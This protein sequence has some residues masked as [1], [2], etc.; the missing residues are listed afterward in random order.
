LISFGSTITVEKIDL[1]ADNSVEFPLHMGEGIDQAVLLVSGTTRFTRQTTGY[2][3][4]IL[5]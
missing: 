4:A 5:P 3:I 2:R 1:P